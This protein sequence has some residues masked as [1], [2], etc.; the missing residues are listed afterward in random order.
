MIIS[1]FTSSV[2]IAHDDSWQVRL[3]AALHSGACG[4]CEGVAL[5]HLRADISADIIP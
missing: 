2:F 1:C 4:M 3:I 5:N